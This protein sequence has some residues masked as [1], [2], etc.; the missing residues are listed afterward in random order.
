VP[1]PHALR[2][3]RT[4]A[5]CVYLAESY[6]PDV[7]AE[8]V[9]ALRRRLEDAAAFARREGGDVRLVGLAAL[10]GDEALLSLLAAPC[11]EAAARAVERAD[12]AADRIVRALWRAGEAG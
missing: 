11:P 7:S 8:R 2:S 1:H 5:Q 9:D 4:T 12:V 10:P 6:L 3:R